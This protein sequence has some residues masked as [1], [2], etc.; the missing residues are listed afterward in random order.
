MNILEEQVLRL[1]GE[2]VDS[3]DVFTD[4]STGLAQIRESLNDAIEEIALVTGGTRGVYHAPLRADSALYRV[5]LS[6][7]HLAWVTDVWLYGQKRRL[8]QTDLRRLWNHN[9]RWMRNSGAP[10]SYFQI[11]WRVI[12][13]WP[14]PAATDMARLD[15]VI[16]PSRYTLDTDRIKLRKSFQWAAVHFA[17]S[18][19][20]AGRGDARTALSHYQRYIE[21]VGL[22]RLYPL[23]AERRRQFQTEKEPW[24]KSTD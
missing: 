13:F 18:E 23:A 4:D 21:A 15:C 12:G 9:P 16:A 17:V 24:P 19:F 5:S 2:D 10:H 6:S 1:I 20:W 11:G 22:Q 8:E 14:K 3:P 7:G